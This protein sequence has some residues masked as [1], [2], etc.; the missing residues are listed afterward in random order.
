M[1]ILLPYVRL[2]IYSW[3]EKKFPRKKNCFNFYCQKYEGQIKT[4][5]HS[6]NNTPE[7]AKKTK[8][9]KFK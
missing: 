7:A 5:T 4:N 8:K 6:T 9:E 1:K 2:A 3:D